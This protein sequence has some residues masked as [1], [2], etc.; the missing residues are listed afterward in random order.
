MVLA[1]YE[2]KQRGK[3]P[4]LHYLY[5]AV[6][7]ACSSPCFWVRRFHHGR[8]LVRLSKEMND[9]TESENAHLPLTLTLFP[10]MLR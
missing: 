3:Q 9:G 2:T 5:E 8:P 7:A 6:T 1:D 10:N 4:I